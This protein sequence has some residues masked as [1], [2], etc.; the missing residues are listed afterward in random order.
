[1][2]QI[3]EVGDT[4]SLKEFAFTNKS[5][6]TGMSARSSF[7]EEF[8]GDAVV[9]I[10]HMFYDDEC[11]YRYWGKAISDDLIQYLNRNAG[12]DRRILFD[13]LQS[14]TS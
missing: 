3:P 7:S 8:K 12:S 13:Q 6:G 9:T 2:I 14:E 11:G 4:V 5:G 10:I 1:M